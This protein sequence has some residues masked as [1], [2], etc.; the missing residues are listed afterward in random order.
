MSRLQTAILIAAAA[1]LAVA[2]EWSAH[3]LGDDVRVVVADG[4]VGFVV[5]CAGVVAAGRHPESRVGPLMGLTGATWFAGSFWPG[6]LFLH[7][8]PLVHLHLSYP[9]GRPR[10]K[11]AVAAIAAS[12]ATAIF[13]S[14]ARNDTVSIAIAVLIAGA[15]ACGFLRASGTTRRA[16]VPALTAALAFAGMLA[17]GAFNRLGGWEADEAVVW[18]YDVVV[19]GGVILLLVD[20]IRSRWADDVVTD[21][22]V[23]VGSRA[24]T[25]TLRDALR[26][27]LDDPSLVVGYWLSDDARY[28]DDAGAPVEIAQPGL[29]RVVTSI[30]SDGGPV[31]V[32]VHDAAV[33]QDADL[34]DAVAAAARFAVS[35]AR[36]Q[37][38]TRER[39]LEIAASRR[40]IV[41]A[42]DAQRQ[43]IERDLRDGVQRRMS[44]VAK[45]L[46]CVR[47]DI[48]EPTTSL[49]DELDRELD[50]TRAELDDLA[51]GI[52]PRALTDNGLAAALGALS[53]GLAL[54]V[55]L[56][57]TNWRLPQ[58]VEAAVY[59]MCAEGLANV[60][61]HA[62]ATRVVLEVAESNGTVVATI[63]DD[64]IG[65]ADRAR[66][67]GL[68]GLSDRIEAVGGELVVHP[69]S[70]GGTTLRAVIPV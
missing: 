61:K 26:R 19:A 32:L 63:E 13:A 14:L 53:T 17:L 33:P 66:G 56:T 54:P 9:T 62:D 28:V 48:D 42:G 30:E 1:G 64:G 52:H 38:E 10:R 22:V 44:T 57:V 46:A 24:D 39:V 47:A 50:R 16:Q 45:L 5:L 31:A 58:A 7:R 2:A 43:L 35:N 12:Y 37:A 69:R 6:L 4:V 51:R 15:A 27:A 68:R 67:S 60:A 40:R 18:A 70:G 3:Q 59:F 36:L 41:E 23:D 20:L 34:V 21:L 11:L 65:G 29:D 55:R 25:G 8:G 49:L